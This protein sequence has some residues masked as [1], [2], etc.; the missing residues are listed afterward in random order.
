MSEILENSHT[1]RD[2]F[3]SNAVYDHLK[4]IAQISLPAIGTLY[5][6]L[7]QYWNWQNS[8]QILGSIMAVDAFLGI[9]LGYSTVKYNKSDAKYDGQIEVA[10]L[11]NGTKR[12]QLNLNSDPNNLDRQSEVVFK[13]KPII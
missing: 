1:V 4:R 5:F 8:E 2:H 3:M 12:F 6:A 7:A 10:Q 9:L 11:E 13:I